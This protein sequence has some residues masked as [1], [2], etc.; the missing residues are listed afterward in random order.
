MYLAFYGLKKKPFNLNPDPQFLFM[1][2][3]HREA[4][5]HM[6]YGIT[7]G[8]WFIA[9]TGDIGIGKTT[10]CYEL[11]EKLDDETLTA[12][13][14]NPLQC[15]RLFADPL[16]FAEESKRELPVSFNNF[17]F[18]QLDQGRRVILIIDEAQHLSPSL[19]ERIRLYSNVEARDENF[20]QIILVGQ[21]ELM[22]KLLSPELRALNQRISIRHQINPLDRGEIENYI[23]HRLTVAGA[24]ENIT[25]SPSALKYIYKYSR[26][27]PRIINL[28]CDR[29]LLSGYIN[30][31]SFITKKVVKQGIESL[32]GRG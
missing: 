15:Y 28:V 32:E 3:D 19:L 21:L 31:T 2:E 1:S 25:F 30:K 29:T 24:C 8:E 26:G 23:A 22:D 9:I 20:L 12:V 11:V 6:F 14:L 5:S 16:M 27:I 4:L 13:L 17:I 7:Q 18:H 10:I